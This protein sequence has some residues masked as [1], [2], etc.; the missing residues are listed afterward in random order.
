MSIEKEIKQIVAGEISLATTQAETRHSELMAEM[1]GFKELLT[2]LLSTA[3]QM[4]A[5]LSESEK[6][7]AVE[8]V[9]EAVETPAITYEDLKGN[10]WSDEQIAA[11]DYSN[12]LPAKPA[13]TDAERNAIL[14]EAVAQLPHNEKGSYTENLLHR[15]AKSLGCGAIEEVTNEQVVEHSVAIQVCVAE[16][17]EF[18]QKANSE[19]VTTPPP[20]PATSTV[21]APPG[22]SAET[23]TAPASPSAELTPAP[24]VGDVV[25]TEKV[26]LNEAAAGGTVPPAPIFTPGGVTTV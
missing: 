6:T 15:I 17:V 3:V 10:G 9:A 13:V 7:E 1:R 12:L 21:P 4:S 23:A 18:I 11:S 8:A 14:D 26:L 16:T 19:K 25:S 22:K 5:D 2:G 20:P 24:P